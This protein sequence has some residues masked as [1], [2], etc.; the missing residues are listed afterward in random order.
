MQL[1][2]SLFLLSISNFASVMSFTSHEVK[3]RSLL[4]IATVSSLKNSVQ[5]YRKFNEMLIC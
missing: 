5:I 4:F 1:I 2:E 3:F